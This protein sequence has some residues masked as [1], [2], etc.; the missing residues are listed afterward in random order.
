MHLN[1]KN[2]ICP[3]VA[4]I[5]WKYIKENG[6]NFHKLKQI[7]IENN[8][9]FQFVY[10]S[11]YPEVY[12]FVTK[13]GIK[14]RNNFHLKLKDWKDKKKYSQKPFEG[15]FFKSGTTSSD[16]NHPQVQYERNS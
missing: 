14:L 3:G 4:N 6:Q 2:V 10:S 8:K 12:C 11:T 5:A 7:L 9:I 13:R 1:N 15:Y 16:L